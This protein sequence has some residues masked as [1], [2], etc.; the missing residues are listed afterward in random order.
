M[1]L[2]FFDDFKLGVLRGDAV[3]D[4]SDVVREVP[5]TGPH[6]LING[7]IERFGTYR[8]PLEN[9]ARGAGGARPPGSGR[10]GRV[11]SI[12]TVWRSFTWKTAR[13][14]NRLPSMPSTNLRPAS[15]AT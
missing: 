5:Y 1:K 9:A 12:S 15:S 4:V 8:R 10:H 6:D 14:R 7:L 11:P 3:V 13:G 2:I